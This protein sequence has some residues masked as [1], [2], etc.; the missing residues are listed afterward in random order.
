MWIRVYGA[1]LSLHDNQR[2]RFCSSP[3]MGGGLLTQCTAGSVFTKMVVWHG[4]SRKLN[5]VL[6]PW[7]KNLGTEWHS[8]YGIATT[9]DHRDGYFKRENDPSLVPQACWGNALCYE[10]NPELWSTSSLLVKTWC[11]SSSV[12]VSLAQ[13][14]SRAA[15][16]GAV[17][18]VQSRRR[19]QLM[20]YDGNRDTTKW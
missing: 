17:Q 7:Y 8:E 11:P 19:R 12:S 13:Y 2:Q 5:P 16:K 1:A 20:S 14:M 9:R 10:D 15:F 6:T 3:W 4:G 18:H